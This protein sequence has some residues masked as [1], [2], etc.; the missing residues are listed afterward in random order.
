MLTREQI[1]GASDVKREEV[2][3]PEWGGSVLVSVMSGAARDAW[4]STL[5]GP[6]GKAVLT[7][8][9]AKLVAACVVDEGGAP[10]F[11]AA[12]VEALSARSSIALERIVRVARRLNKLG[13]AEF[14]E[15][16]KNSEPSRPA[17]SSSD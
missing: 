10:L 1:L 2:K 14:K 17:S 3:V 6:D 9:R 16:E 7:D 12:D 4:E 15:A 5:I 11:S 8:A 13:D